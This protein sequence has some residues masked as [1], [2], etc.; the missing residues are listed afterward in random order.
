V[1]EIAFRPARAAVS[2]AIAELYQM[3]AGGVADY[4]WSG[5]AGPGESVLDAGTRRFQRG[6]TNFSYQ[7]A[8]LPSV[9]ATS[10]A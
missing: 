2:P 5:L 1:D 9:T 4:T 3:A 7:L 8:W 10:S 6:N